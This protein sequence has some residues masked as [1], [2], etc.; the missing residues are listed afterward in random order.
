[1]SN[2]TIN[3]LAFGEVECRSFTNVDPDVEGIE[4]SIHG[5]LVGS[6]IGESLPDENDED[7]VDNFGDKVGTW[8][9]D[10]GH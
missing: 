9:I 10:N 8:L 4:I 7:E 3:V 5:D 2:I 6:M 1:M